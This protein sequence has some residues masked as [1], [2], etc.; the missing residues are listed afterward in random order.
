MAGMP[1]KVVERAESV[2]QGLENNNSQPSKPVQ[3]PSV[4]P[5]VEEPKPNK[6][7]NL[8]G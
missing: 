8:F 4:K 1:T 7:L 2:L 6:Q 3:K 5:V